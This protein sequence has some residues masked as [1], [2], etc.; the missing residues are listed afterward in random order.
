[1]SVAKFSQAATADLRDIWLYSAETWGVA[2]ADRYTVELE[3]VCD[4]LASGKLVSRPVRERA[5][6]FRYTVGR[7]LIFFKE[8]DDGILVM[9]V[10]H[11]SMD[12]E[13]HLI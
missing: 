4:G 1:M 2:Q 6:Y 13:R 12:A 7:H 3:E 8:G 10:L 11:Q 5:G 9:R